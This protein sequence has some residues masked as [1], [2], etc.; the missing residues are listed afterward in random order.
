MRRDRFRLQFIVWMVF[1]VIRSTLDPF[2]LHFESQLR[3]QNFSFIV[4][5][6][7]FQKHLS[8]RLDSTKNPLN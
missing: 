4:N 5:G 6:F 3:V 1:V 7:D 2:A 8:T